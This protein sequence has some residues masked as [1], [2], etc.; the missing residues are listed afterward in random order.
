MPRAA[1]RPLA[2]LNFQLRNGIQWGTDGGNQGFH[3]ALEKGERT[4]RVVASALSFRGK[5]GS[6]LE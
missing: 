3:S 4:G 5:I 2:R 6:F 1:E